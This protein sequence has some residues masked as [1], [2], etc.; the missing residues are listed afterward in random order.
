MIRASGVRSS[1]LTLAKNC[2]LISSS[3]R[4]RSSSPCSSMFL[5]RDLPLL[6]LLLG[7]VAPLAGDEHHFA[8]SSLTGMSEAS[9]MIVSLPPARP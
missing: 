9:M 5:L 8:V 4:M 6:R 2:V 7:D 1:W 3:S